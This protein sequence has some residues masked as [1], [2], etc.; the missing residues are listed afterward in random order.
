MKTYYS[1]VC[2]RLKHNLGNVVA[3]IS[4][5]E[6][7]ELIEE[8]KH[9]NEYKDTVGDGL[10]NKTYKKGNER[11]QQDRTL[12]KSLVDLNVSSNDNYEE[13]IKSYPNVTKNAYN[14]CRSRLKKQLDNN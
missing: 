3:R 13:I 11:K 2:D 10:V 12:W 4:R 7:K 6:L 5:K 8:M 14:I 9:E 1:E